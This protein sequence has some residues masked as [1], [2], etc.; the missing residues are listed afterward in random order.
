MLGHPF[1][2][3]AARW[4]I[5]AWAAIGILS[6]V[7]SLFVFVILP[8]RI[9]FPP[10]ILAMI[11]VYLL[12]PLV[13]ALERRGIRRVWGSLM[14]YAV[15]ASV[16]GGSLYFLVPLLTEQVSAFVNAA[17]RILGRASDTFRD[18]AQRFGIDV[19]Q[20][21]AV[22]TETVSA[23]FDR[24]VSITQG[25]VGLAIILIL[26]PILAFYF[27]V[28]LPKIKRSL[29]A[30]IPARRRADVEAVMERIGRAVGGFFRGQLLVALFVGVASSFAL[31]I[32]GLPFW[33]LV[34]LATGLFNLVP[35]IGPFIGGGI[36]ILVAF[37]ADQP[38]GGLLHLAPGWRLAVGSAVALVI[39]QQLDNHIMSPNIV[40]RT[41]KLHPVTVMLGL[42]VGA[43]LMGLF[44]MIL[45][46]PVIASVKILF[47]HYW[48]TRMTWPPGRSEAVVPASGGP[49]HGPSPPGAASPPEDAGGARS[50]LSARAAAPGW[51]T[52]VRSL[53]AGR[54]RAG[55]G[56]EAAEP[57]ER[58]SRGEP[59]PPAG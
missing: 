39:V 42:L 45:A 57:V 21:P 23:F 20:A 29:R 56:G 47:L 33:I 55:D 8:I 48:D 35:L 19:G 11:V 54:R 31:W 41:V 51:V 34:G 49:H 27:L 2:A 43:T 32:V 38:T 4:G 16:V 18:L 22:G 36:A 53:F 40:G 15:F 59:G 25:I 52:M 9:I 46:I 58:G 13:S 6:L 12:N 50:P 14:V 10:L 30:S 17:P 26:G 7:I 5:V 1:V 28:D 37:A 44:G 3:R 24:L